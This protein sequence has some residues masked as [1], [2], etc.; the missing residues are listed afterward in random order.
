MTEIDSYHCGGSKLPIDICPNVGY[1]VV[2]AAVMAAPGAAQR[3]A[4][5]HTTRKGWCSAQRIQIS[6]IASGNHTLIYDGHANYIDLSHPA[7]D[8]DDQSKKQKPPLG[9]VTVSRLILEQF[10]LTPG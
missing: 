10:R 2:G 1:S 7:L 9:K 3:Q 5:S 8:C 4:V 6:M